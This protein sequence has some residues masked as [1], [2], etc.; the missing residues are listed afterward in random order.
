VISIFATDEDGRDIHDMLPCAVAHENNLVLK[1]KYT[2][3]SSKIKI[4]DDLLISQL[5][6]YKVLTS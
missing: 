1:C 6:G 3:C 5:L 2:H 4:S